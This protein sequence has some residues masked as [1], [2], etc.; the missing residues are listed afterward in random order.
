MDFAFPSVSIAKNPFGLLLVSLDQ[1][2]SIVKHCVCMWHGHFFDIVRDLFVVHVWICLCTVR[3]C[4]CMVCAVWW[5]S[6]CVYCF[7][8]HGQNQV[9]QWERAR[10]WACERARTRDRRDDVGFSCSYF[11]LVRAMNWYWLNAYAYKHTHTLAQSQLHKYTSEA[12]ML[13]M[14]FSFHFRMEKTCN[15]RYSSSRRTHTHAH[16]NCAC[17]FVCVCCLFLTHFVPFRRDRLWCFSYW[18]R[19]KHTN[20]NIKQTHLHMLKWCA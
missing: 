1:I 5:V 20:T 3:L 6:T 10:K 11:K 13:S 19:S 15:V 2:C 16:V 8:V 4:M 14:F 17:V 18:F 7:C 12:F 9:A